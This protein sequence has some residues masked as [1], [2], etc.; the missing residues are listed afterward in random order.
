[1][2]S[3]D[4]CDILGIPPDVNIDIS[5]LV[6]WDRSCRQHTLAQTEFRSGIVPIGLR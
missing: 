6:E 3:L 4:S 2:S 1:M 5:S